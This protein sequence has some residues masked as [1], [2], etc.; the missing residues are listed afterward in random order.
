MEQNETT[1]G[2]GDYYHLRAIA[3]SEL[4]AQG[5]TEDGVAKAMFA[6]MLKRRTTPLLILAVLCA[7]VVPGLLVLFSVGPEWLPPVLMVFGFIC[8]LSSFLVSSIM[9]R[10]PVLSRHTGKPL[11]KYR[12]LTPGMSVRISTIYV[13][14]D[15]KTYFTQTWR[16]TSSDMY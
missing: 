13:C 6:R 4:I 11:I 15:S 14:P 2:I 8:V 7:I 9:Y 3:T 10:C 1:M 16:E 5:Y 12:N